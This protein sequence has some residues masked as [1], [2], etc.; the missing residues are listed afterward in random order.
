MPDTVSQNE[1]KA[2]ERELER[3]SNSSNVRPEFSRA[4]LDV[5]AA[6]NYADEILVNSSFEAFLS[7]LSDVTRSLIQRE[8][9]A[10]EN[11]KTAIRQGW[12]EYV[13]GSPLENFDDLKN[14]IESTIDARIFVMTQLRDKLVKPLEEREYVVANG[15]QLEDAI[16][17]FRQF[18]QDILRDWPSSNKPPSPLNKRAIA[19]AREAVAK[20]EKGMRKNELIWG[21]TP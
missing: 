18:R 17:D 10:S 8:L 13:D 5:M 15:Q 1:L 7:S 9:A 3:L 14:L 16:R 4:M 6:L 19:E 20:G 12:R 11:T 2:L 21:K